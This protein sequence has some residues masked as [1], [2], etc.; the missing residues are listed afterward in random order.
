MSSSDSPLIPPVPDGAVRKRNVLDVL[1]ALPGPSKILIRVD[2][3]VPMDSNGTITDDSRIKGALPTIRAVLQ[4]GHIPILC[5]H[6]GRPELVQKGSPEDPAVLKQ[7]TELSLRPI[8]EYLSNL[9]DGIP[10]LFADDCQ[11]ATATIEKLTP[12]DIGLLENLRFYKAEEKND[13]AFA[14]ILASYVDAYINDAFGTCHRAHAS[15]AG[16]P[17]IMTDKSR[18]GIG[19]L[20][21][22]ELAFLDFTN[23]APTD[24]ISAIIGGSK[25]STKLPVVCICLFCF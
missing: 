6:M 4:A 14:T 13:P 23:V 21:A 17:N 9:M 7:R 5:S 1:A 16:V 24:K 22:S 2:F 18:I 10:V 8:G 19:A 25:V 12:G 3:N 11:N 20:V 15:T